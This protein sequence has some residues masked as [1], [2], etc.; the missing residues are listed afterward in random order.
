MV[1]I[2]TNSIDVAAEPRFFGEVL[3]GEAD[4]DDGI[5][6]RPTWIQG[7]VAILFSI[8]IEHDPGFPG[9]PGEGDMVP[10]T[11]GDL[12]LPSHHS[13]PTDVEAEM[14]VTDEEGLS[15]MNP[16]T[17]CG[18]LRKDAAVLGGLNPG[19]KGHLITGELEIVVASPDGSGR[20][21]EIKRTTLDS[22][23]PGHPFEFQVL[24]TIDDTGHPLAGTLVAIPARQRLR[25][26]IAEPTDH[27]HRL[28]RSSHRQTRRRPVHPMQFRKIAVFMGKFDALRFFTGTSHDRFGSFIPTKNCIFLSRECDS[29]GPLCGR[30]LLPHQGQRRG[31][32]EID[33]FGDGAKLRQL[34]LA[35]DGCDVDVNRPRVCL[36]WTGHQHDPPLVRGHSDGIATTTNIDDHHGS[37]TQQ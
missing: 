21:I 11:V 5:L 10:A 37:P 14:S 18:G 36:C 31:V 3:R 20:A 28:L 29:L 23:S 12:L 22:S 33:P 32:T 4:L 15:V 34:L 27:N 7:S 9:I 1:T 35:G 16:R 8:D 30:P 6:D 26:G 24:H 25:K 17:L 2:D 13:N 19:G